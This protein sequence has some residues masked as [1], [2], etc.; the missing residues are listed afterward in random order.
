M[1]DSSESSID[2]MPFRIAKNG[3]NRCAQRI[4]NFSIE[5]ILSADF[6]KD[7]RERPRGDED[8]NEKKEDRDTKQFS[9]ADFQSK[10]SKLKSCTTN[11]TPSL[12]I[13]YSL[14]SFI[15]A[16]TTEAVCKMIEWISIRDAVSLNS[17]L[18]I[19]LV[20]LRLSTLDSASY[21]YLQ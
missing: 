17:G 21:G 15:Y 7:G 11:K 9:S 1:K 2:F 19:N 8:L 10:K 4:S 6:G 16:T 3:S 13:F 20:P 14:K 18:I 12:I 5:Y